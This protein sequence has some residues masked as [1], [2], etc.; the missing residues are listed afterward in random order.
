M[1]A[2]IG[3]GA[4]LMRIDGF[5]AKRPLPRTLGHMLIAILASLPVTQAVLLARESTRQRCFA[6]CGKPKLACKERFGGQ[7]NKLSAAPIELRVGGNAERPR[8]M[9][10]IGEYANGFRP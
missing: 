4:W 5:C 1:I 6:G 9:I 10:L 8:H 3:I 2:R 7:G